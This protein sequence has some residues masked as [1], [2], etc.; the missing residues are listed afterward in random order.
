[1]FLGNVG[2]SLCVHTASQLGRPTSQ[3]DNGLQATEMKF[4]RGGG[5]GYTLMDRQEL[6]N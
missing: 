6:R 5:T 1:M 2:I 4:L 3:D